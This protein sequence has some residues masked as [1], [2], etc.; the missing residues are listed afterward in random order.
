MKDKNEEL[1]PAVE[2]MAN[3]IEQSVVMDIP[4]DYRYSLA[5]ETMLTFVKNRRA[6]T[7]KECADLYEVTYHQWIM[8]A[9]S[10]EAL[11]IQQEISNYTKATARSARTAAIFSGLNFFLK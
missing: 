1:T 11:R 9:N 2:S 7:W 5:L 10:A 8:Q 4:R 3:E 6:S